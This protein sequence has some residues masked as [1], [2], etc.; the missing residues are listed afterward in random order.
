M[1]DDLD[2]EMQ[3]NYQNAK[4]NTRRI[5]PYLT[6][7]G[8]NST[9]ALHPRRGAKPHV[10]LPI[11]GLF[12]FFSFAKAVGHVPVML[13]AVVFGEKPTKGCLLYTSPSPRDR[14]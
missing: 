7:D 5:F 10:F 4:D 3:V 1:F 6:Y 11:D 9:Y 14:G 12:A 8:A 2:K 13:Y